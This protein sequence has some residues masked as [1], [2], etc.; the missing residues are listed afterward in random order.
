MLKPSSF[1]ADFAGVPS[2]CAAAD[3]ALF[4]GIV[5]VVCTSQSQAPSDC[6]E[7]VC[8]RGRPVSLVCDLEIVE[9]FRMERVRARPAERVSLQ[10]P[11]PDPWR[12]L[13]RTSDK[14]K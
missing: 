14:I 4:L 10:A 9:R 7:A 11:S 2:S 8:G 13:D 3:A 5:Y 6:R 12:R 1:G